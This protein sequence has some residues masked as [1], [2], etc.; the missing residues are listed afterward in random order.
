MDIAEISKNNST[1]TSTENVRNRIKE[2]K[3]INLSSISLDELDKMLNNV[4]E[5]IPFPA[6]L[7]A[8]DKI[9]YRARVNE[10][11]KEFENITDLGIK[12]KELVMHFGRAN[13]PN[14]SIFYSASNLGLACAEVLHNL[15]DSYNRKIKIAVTTISEWKIQKEIYIS[16]IFNS[17]SVLN[18]RKDMESIIK[19]NSKYFLS[20]ELLKKDIIDIS[21]LILE[22]FSDEFSK[23]NIV[24]PDDYKLSVWYVYNLTRLN[25]IAMEK[26]GRKKYDGIAYPGVAMKYRGDN[27]ALFNFDLDSKIKFIT[28]YKIICTNY[29][30]ENGKFDFAKIRKV[31][32]VDKNGKLNWI[33]LDRKL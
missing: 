7:I 3:N 17:K 22:F 11:E 33:D 15:K 16:P 1:F 19:K 23:N 32:S 27:I 30:F 28:A 4:F 14:E 24:T 25:D 6:G 20:K 13:L 9:I 12:P 2:L 5:F 31:D 8:Q 21:D 29:D 10:N 18:I 26:Y